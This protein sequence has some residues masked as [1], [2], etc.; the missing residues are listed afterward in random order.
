MTQEQ[1]LNILKTGANIFLTGEPGAGKTHIV[2]TYVNYLRTSDVEPAITASTGIAATHIGG[3]TIH[4]WSGIGIKTK[5]DKHDLDKIASTKYI[6]NRVRRAKV[7]IIDEVSMLSSNTL[8]MLDAVCRRI[9]LSSKPFGGLQIVFVGDFFQLPPIVKK[10]AEDD[11]QASLISAEVGSSL[12]RED[13]LTRFAYGSSAW[14][15]A[16]P[17]VCYLTEQYRQDDQNFLFILLAIRRNTFND[18]HLR[19]LE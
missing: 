3:M 14:T 11:A 1:A 4:S 10:E 17:I 19:H 6:E 7:L 8:S 5:L 2:N 13:S 16:N 12:G 18:N 15:L 9:R